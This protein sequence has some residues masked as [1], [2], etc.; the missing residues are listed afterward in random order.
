LIIRGRTNN[1][2]LG[3][4]GRSRSKSKSRKIKCLECYGV[5]HFRKNYI[6]R[7]DKRKYMETF[8]AANV[9]SEEKISDDVESVPTLSFDSSSDE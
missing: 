5:R 4:G 7:K 1:K 3:S 2:S 9:A 8:D 6:K